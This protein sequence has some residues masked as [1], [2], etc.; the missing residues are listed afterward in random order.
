MACA[1]PTRKTCSSTPAT[2]IAAATDGFS[3]SARGGVATTMRPT[4]ATRAGIAFMRTDEGYAPA[5]P[6]T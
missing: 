3:S 6:G 1:P 5:P 4:P 2:T